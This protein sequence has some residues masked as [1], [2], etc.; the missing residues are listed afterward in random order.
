MEID[1][2]E[3]GSGVQVGAALGRIRPMPAIMIAIACPRD[4]AT[5]NGSPFAVGSETQAGMNRQDETQRRAGHQ[6]D[7][8]QGDQREQE[9]YC[10]F[11]DHPDFASRCSMI[12][13]GG[14]RFF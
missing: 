13:P 9:L 11:S 8:D 7:D 6:R 2:T 1:L 4:A 14:F 12:G 3:G 5:F 10:L